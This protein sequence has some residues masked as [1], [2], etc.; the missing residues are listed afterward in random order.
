MGERGSDRGGEMGR[1]V[2]L[3][4]SRKIDK[5][6]EEVERQRKKRYRK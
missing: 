5:E 2:I 1:G 4:L 6:K 3:S